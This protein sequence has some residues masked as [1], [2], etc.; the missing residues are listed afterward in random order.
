MKIN[1]LIV[2]CAL[3]PL[4]GCTHA[5]TT[6]EAASTPAAIPVQTAVAA[7]QAVDVTVTVHGTLAAAE[8]DSA[9]IAP[10][11]TG[12]LLRVLVREG[13]H[14]DKG[15]L[16]AVVDNRPDVAQ[17]RAAAAATQVAMR[18]RNSNVEQAQAA[19]TTARLNYQKMIAGSRP[20][21]IAEARQAT[22]RDLAT[23]QQARKNL[24]RQNMLFAGGVSSAQ[25]VEDARTALRVAEAA[26]R[27]SS[28]QLSLVEA[29]N[30]PQ[31]IRTAAVQAQAAAV[32]LQQAQSLGD[33]KVR[34]AEMAQRAARATAAN[35]EVRSPISGRVV[36]RALDEGDVASPGTPIMTVADTHDLVL[37]ATTPASNQQALKR[38]EVASL[39]F[40]GVPG[41]FAGR[42]LTATDV[43]PQTGMLELRLS[44]DNP[45]QALRL[46]QYGEADI[47]V[48]HLPRAVVVPRAALVRRDGKDVVLVVKDGIAHEQEVQVVHTA[49]PASGAE[50]VGLRGGLQAGE[51]VVSVGSYEIEDG[52]HVKPVAARTPAAQRP[53]AP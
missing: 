25:Q 37:V 16:V 1:L 30:R 36:H 34:Q 50:T 48:S 23:L 31:D 10:V 26:L 7:A 40:D 49:G 11:I 6:S 14:V 39:R 8:S 18:E 24:E 15:Q 9:Q 21:E 12:R 32:A 3:L 17:E 13:D 35:G 42:V 2:L 46:G 45:A 19:L 5:S 29:G 4:V 22:R 52:A 41:S 47:V 43:D 53:A 44:V 38:G 28:Q 27:T 20:Q 33:A 51:T